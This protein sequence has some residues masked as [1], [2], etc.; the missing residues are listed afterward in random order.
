MLCDNRDTCSAVHRT[1]ALKPAQE[2]PRRVAQTQK[3]AHRHILTC[4]FASI[5][6]VARAKI[7]RQEMPAEGRAERPLYDLL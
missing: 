4:A 3:S 7:V 6:T 1:F 2:V 5:R